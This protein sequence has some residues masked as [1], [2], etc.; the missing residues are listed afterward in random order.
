MKTEFYL[1]IPKGRSVAEIAR[2]ITKLGKTDLVVFLTQAD[3]DECLNQGL[4]EEVGNLLTAYVKLLE[5]YQIK[6][7]EE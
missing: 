4:K 7:E 5:R 1:K 3:I 2:E 6:E